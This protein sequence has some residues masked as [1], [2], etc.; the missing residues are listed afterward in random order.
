MQKLTKPTGKNRKPAAV[1]ADVRITV[2]EAFQN[3]LLRLG[4]P[5]VVRARLNAAIRAGEVRLW[6]RDAVIDPNL[7]ETHLRV[8][9]WVEPD[10][11]WVGE[12]EATKAINEP[13]SCV[14][15]ISGADVEALLAREAEPERHPGGAPPRYDQGQILIEAA[16]Y[17]VVNGLP[18]KQDQLIAALR[19]KL[20]DKAPEVSR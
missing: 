6:D 20:A 19:R 11:R 16:A 17:V 12:I 13:K 8:A 7:F 9:A 5:H 10:G 3:L 18:A 14:W 4:K 2:N 15:T 1:P